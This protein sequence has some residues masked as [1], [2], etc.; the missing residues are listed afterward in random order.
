MGYV[1]TWIGDFE[2]EVLDSAVLEAMAHYNSTYDEALY[3][4]AYAKLHE[5]F[6]KLLK[7]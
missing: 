6:L 1:T 3:H 7:A 4:V 2:V 5:P